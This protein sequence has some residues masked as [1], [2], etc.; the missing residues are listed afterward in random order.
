MPLEFLSLDGIDLLLQDG[1]R[2]ADS[3]HITDL[4]GLV[5]LLARKHHRMQLAFNYGRQLHNRPGCGAFCGR[6]LLA[7]VLVST[8]TSTALRRHHTRLGL[9]LKLSVNLEVTPDYN[10]LTFLQATADQIIIT[11]PEPQ[12]NFP[13]FKSRLVSIRNLHI[14][15]STGAGNQGSSSRYDQWLLKPFNITADVTH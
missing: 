12:N 10:A 9:Y 8:S 5:D 2:R 7:P 4:N 13:S 1:E 11:G 6:H 14:H 3:S 15:N